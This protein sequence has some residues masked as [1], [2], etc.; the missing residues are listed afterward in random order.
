MKKPRKPPVTH[1][2][3]YVAQVLYECRGITRDAADKLMISTTSVLN[4]IRNN[5]CCRDAREAGISDLLSVAED[6]VMELVYNKDKAATFFVLKTLGK[7]RWN[8][9]EETGKEEKEEDLEFVVDEGN[10][11]N[12]INSDRI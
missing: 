2:P 5:P 9:N 6:N 8:E 12:E 11:E 10:G 1:K 7:R 4:Y 3:S